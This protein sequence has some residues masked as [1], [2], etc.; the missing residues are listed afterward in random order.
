MQAATQDLHVDEK[1][2][3]SSES[4]RSRTLL[5]ASVMSSQLGVHLHGVCGR[6]DGRYVWEGRDADCLQ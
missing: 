6:Y 2:I 4:K 5:H 1:L 3:A